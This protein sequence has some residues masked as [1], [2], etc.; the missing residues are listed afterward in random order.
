[1]ASSV[2]AVKGDTVP[3]AKPSQRVSFKADISTSIPPPEPSLVRENWADDTSRIPSTEGENE[4]TYKR[5]SKGRGDPWR[6]KSVLCLGAIFAK[7]ILQC[8]LLTIK[9]AAAFEVIP[10][11]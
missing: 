9:M 5:T 4:T 6:T 2:D 3:D 10:P 1:M 11:S 7:S 8:F